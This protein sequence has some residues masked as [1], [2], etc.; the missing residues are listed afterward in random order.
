MTTAHNYITTDTE[1]CPA[2][3]GAAVMAWQ[4]L[5]YHWA[6]AVH[7]KLLNVKITRNFIIKEIYE[8]QK[9]LMASAYY[10]NKLPQYEKWIADG[11]AQ[12]VPFS[13]AWEVWKED[14]KTYGVKAIIAHNTPFDRDALRNTA[15]FIF[16]KPYRIFSQSVELWDSMKI[17]K[18]TF[19]K[20]TSYRKFCETNNYL[21]KNGK[22]R[23]TAEICYQYITKDLDF[24]EEHTALEDVK[25]EMAITGKGFA[26]HRKMAR[27]MRNP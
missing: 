26:T 5:V 23:F 4:M 2:F 21:T 22:C 9:A 8:G 25:I 13:E 14:V 17:A 24:E 10:A 19:G 7:D 12:L 20:Y 15:K 1:A 27:V 6:W 16:G 11:T 18:S 3:I